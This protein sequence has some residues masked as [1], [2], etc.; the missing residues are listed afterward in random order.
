[1]K[2]TN[3]LSISAFRHLYLAQ[4][5]SLLGTGIASV[6][7]ALLAW[8]LAGDQAGVVLGTALALKMVA[9]VFISPIIG[10]LAHR[11]PRKTVLIGLDIIR[12]GLIACLPWVSEIWHIYALIFAINTCAAGFTPLFQ[13]TIPDLLQEEKIYTKALSYARLAYDLENILSPT[14]A[15]LLLAVLSFHELFYLDSLTFIISA[16]LIALTIIPKTALSDRPKPIWKNIQFG[17]R[18]YLTTPRLRALWVLYFAV[19]ASGGMMIVN[20]VVYVQGY[21]QM[22]AQIMAMVFMASGAGSMT[23]A[24]TVPHL[25][26]QFADRSIMLTGACLLAIT[27]SLGTQMPNLIGLSILWFMLGFGNSLIQTPAG[28]L[29]WRSCRPSDSAAFFAANFSLSHSGWFIGY[30]L[31]GHLA[32]HFGLTFTFGTLAAVA[33]MALLVA[34]FQFPQRDPVELWHTHESMTH[35]HPHIHDQ[36]H[37]HQHDSGHGHAPH[38]NI[39]HDHHHQH[40][41]LRH[42]HTFVIDQHHTQWPTKE[43]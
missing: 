42:K 31:A 2:S 26:Q 19:A 33:W 10:G 38:S 32:S 25:R 39:D 20:T 24:L 35:V 27:L 18:A 22:D 21:L 8:D 36:H 5:T 29:I 23:A 6:A 3:P 1:M 4:I 17:I 28:N 43:G 16:S 11:L 40:K 14:L 7:L 37:E 15:A 12:A 34:W 9:Y 41:P 30:I 13:A